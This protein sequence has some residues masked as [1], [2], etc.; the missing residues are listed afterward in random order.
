M[1]PVHQGPATVTDVRLDSFLLSA[2]HTPPM[3]VQSAMA[4]STMVT[5]LLPEGS[6][7]ISQPG[8]L[9]WVRRRA[10]TMLPT[11]TVKAWSRRV[12]WLMLGPRLKRSWKLNLALS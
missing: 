12:T 4:G 3:A 9:P 5:V 10:F 6:T 1:Q 7:V 2:M 8:L 11:V